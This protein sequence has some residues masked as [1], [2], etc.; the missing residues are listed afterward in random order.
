MNSTDVPANLGSAAEEDLT[1]RKSL[2]RN[3]LAS[4]AGHF[5]FIA[6]GFV[7][8]RAIDRH[9]GA[10]LLG[11]WSFAWS[12]VT[13]LSLVQAGI[14]SAVNRYIA[15]YRATGDIASVNCAVSSVFCVHLIC[16]GIVLLLASVAALLLPILFAARLKEHIADAQGIVFI[17]GISLGL[18]IVFASFTGVITG[19][20]RWA[21][22]NA[23]KSGLHGLSVAAMVIS[24]SLGGGLVMLALVSAAGLLLADLVRV[25]AAHRVCKGLQVRFRHARLSMATKM[26]RYGAKTLTASIAKLL[27]NQTTRVLVIS[28]LGLA[29]LAYFSCPSALILHTATMVSK[30]SIVLTPTASAVHKGGSQADLQSL[31]VRSARYSLYVSLPVV[32]LLAVFGDTILDAWMGP[33]YANWPLIVVLAVGSIPMLS[34]MPALSLLAGMNA[35][36]RPGLAVLLAAC[37]SAGFAALVLGPLHGGLT[38]AAAA[39]LLPQ[40]FVHGVYVPI[41]ACHLLRLPL[42]RY[43]WR[44]ARGPLSC[45]L[46]FA[47]CLVCARLTLGQMPVVAL[48]VAVLAGGMVLFGL[49]WRYVVPSALK[50]AALRI[51]VPRRTAA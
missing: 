26:I 13:Y 28:F 3:V 6:A 17:L 20:H 21:L 22:H 27:S 15:R 47:A 42:A 8:P 24:L 29:P 2:S 1:G 11:V 48:L 33:D 31:L 38:A 49:Y 40:A 12:L 4:W 45:L 44:T 7:L 36:G 34:Q 50:I 10:E 51:F 5:V 32:L 14:G 19:C 30:L 37:L 25:V 18:Q 41:R 46:P 35:H 23:I 43:Y 9:L 39:I 16:G